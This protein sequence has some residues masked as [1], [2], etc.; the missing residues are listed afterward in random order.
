M[1]IALTVDEMIL[2]GGYGLERCAN[3]LWRGRRGN[4]GFNRDNERWQIDVEGSL[5][6]YVAAKALGL[7]P[8]NPAVDELDS[9]K[10]DIG[11]GLQV[12]STKYLSGSLLIH[13][14]DDDNHVFIL[15]TG[16]YGR[17]T[18][19]GWIYA[20]EGKREEFRK[21]YKGRTA[22]WVGQDCLRPIEDVPLP[23]VAD[24]DLADST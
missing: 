3:A 6:E 5:A 14:S 17:Y 23:R 7:L 15:V 20:R 2:Y 9:E 18:V 21:T 12:R 22:Y 11:P 24:R 4:H 13:D 1:K 10:G 8:F 16:A 19:C